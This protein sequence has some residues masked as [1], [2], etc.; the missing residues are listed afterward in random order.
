MR[1][2]ARGAAKWTRPLRSRALLLP[3]LLVLL[4][5]AAPAAS[6][7]SRLCDIAADRA[8]TATGVPASVLRAISRTESG[9]SR[10][11][12]LRPWP[13]TVNIEGEGRWFDSRAAALDWIE[14]HRARGAVSFD[15]GCFQI[16]H[17]WHGDAFDS[18]AQMFDPEVSG[19]YAARFLA[20]LHAETGDW[21]A[22]AGAYHSRTEALAR[23]YRAR[24][25]RIHAALDPAR[26]ATPAP[27]PAAEPPRANSYPLL[28]SGTGTPRLG[29]LVPLGQAPA[30]RLVALD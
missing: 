23:R 22:A 29:S 7:P 15:V 14:S 1:E 8:A 5:P 28:A 21:S 26:P 30:T 17:R 13:W 10:N 11:G 25:D 27:S 12:A 18:V 9:R 4:M 20:R 2:R 6:D 16:N 24:F 19:L 3:V